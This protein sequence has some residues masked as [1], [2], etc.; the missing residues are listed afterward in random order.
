MRKSRVLMFSVIITIVVFSLIIYL[1]VRTL[2]HEVLL[3][4]YQ[5]Q[6]LAQTRTTQA[7]TSIMAI[8]QQKATRLNAIAD[9]MQR[10]NRSLKEL[11]D[12]D[13]DIDSIFILRKNHLLYPDPQQLL[14]QKELAW[15]Q[16]IMPI[17]NDPSLLYSHSIKNERDIP[18][19][20]WFL[21]D[22]LQNPQLIY[23]HIDCSP[24]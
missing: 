8:L 20:G 17:V 24:P 1:G 23:W 9:Y 21:N 10:D 5:S 15:V 14:S 7:N 2:E 4:H 12:K 6:T 22:E 19:S 3:R 13:S 11:L 18:Q 16:V